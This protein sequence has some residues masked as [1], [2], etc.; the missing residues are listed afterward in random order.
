MADGLAEESDKHKSFPQTPTRGTSAM[1]AYCI[2]SINDL[3]FFSFICDTVVSS[4]YVAHIAQQA[5]DGLKSDEKEPGDR[6]L[7]AGVFTRT[8]T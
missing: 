7:T 4:D 8:G 5:L 2:A 3:R 1:H 6:N